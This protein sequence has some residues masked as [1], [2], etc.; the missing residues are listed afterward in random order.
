MI[1][2]LKIEF[3]GDKGYRHGIWIGFFE[4]NESFLHRKWR[5]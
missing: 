3:E 2:T 1:K 5:N 4:Q